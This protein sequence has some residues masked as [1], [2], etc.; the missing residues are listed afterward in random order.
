MPGF[1]AIGIEKFFSFRPDWHQDHRANPLVRQYQSA[2]DSVL[3]SHP[4]VRGCVAECVHCGIR[5]LTHPRSAGRL[6]LRCPFGC[7]RHYRR[8]C[9]NQ[10]SAAYYAT[11]AGKEKKRRLNAR[12]NCNSQAATGAAKDSSPHDDRVP[13]AKESDEQVPGDLSLALRLEG[14]LLDES[15]LRHSPMLPYVR[16]L[17]S[18]IEG[19]AY[20]CQEVVALLRRSMR[21]HSMSRRSR[22]DYVLAFLHQHP[23]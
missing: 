22:R 11:A 18:L 3:E 13:P 1:F 8:Q 4:H 17:V 10:R 23:P 20:S 19:V 7:R 6:N 21:Q 15:S 14:L 9:S 16:M 2:L 12:R 5:F